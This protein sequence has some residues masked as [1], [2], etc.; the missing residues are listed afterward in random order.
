MKALPVASRL[1]RFAGSVSMKPRLA[2][3]ASSSDKLKSQR[4]GRGRTLA[5]NGT[6]TASASPVAL[7]AG[8]PPVVAGIRCG[9]NAPWWLLPDGM[10]RLAQV[11]RSLD[12]SNL[13]EIVGLCRH[14]PHGR[15]FSI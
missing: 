2:K 1:S 5:Q 15:T 6:S 13:G 12:D 14:N 4:S 11:L 9:A 8:P 7:A 3:L 10:R